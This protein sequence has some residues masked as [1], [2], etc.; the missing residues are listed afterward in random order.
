MVWFGQ[1]QVEKRP[2]FRDV[3]HSNKLLLYFLLG[4][5][6]LNDGDPVGRCLIGGHILEEGR[7]PLRLI[8]CFDL[9]WRKDDVFVS[10]GLAVDPRVAVVE[11][12]H[13]KASFCSHD[14]ALEL[15]ALLLALDEQVL[16]WFVSVYLT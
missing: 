16:Q 4:H 7:D 12:E 8:Y 6:S 3:S 11:L 5:L 1:L 10:D 13:I 2:I 14:A 15:A 9:K